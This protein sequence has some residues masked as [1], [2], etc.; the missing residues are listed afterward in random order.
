VS[1]WA[2]FRRA[3]RRE[4][5]DIDETVEEMKGRANAAIEA[6]E[7]ALDATPSERLAMEQARAGDIDDEIEAIRRRIERKDG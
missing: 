7:R 1:T 5:R 4:A 3:L 2:R 6:R